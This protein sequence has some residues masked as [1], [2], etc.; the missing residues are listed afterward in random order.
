MGFN[1]E[2]GI[3]LGE[4]AKES[5]EEEKFLIYKIGRMRVEDWSEVALCGDLIM[6][7]VWG[8]VG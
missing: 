2:R 1:K 4:M 8:R 6:K 7:M 3:H 5:L